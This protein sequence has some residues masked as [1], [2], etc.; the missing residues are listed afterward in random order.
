MTESVPPVAGRT[1]QWTAL[2]L[3]LLV[4]MR[5]VIGSGVSVGTVAAVLSLP[6]WLPA[7]RRYRSAGLLVGLGVFSA[8]FGVWLGQ[9]S[10]ADHGLKFPDHISFAIDMIGL[11]A[12]VGVLLWARQKLRI[13]TIGLMYG[14]GMLVSAVAMDAYDPSNPWKFGIG[15]PAT[16]IILAISAR[17]T[18]RSVDVVVLGLLAA[19]AVATDSRYRFATL[20]IAAFLVL[21]QMVL[22]RSGPRGSAFA[23]VILFV[24]IAAFTY[25]LLSTLLVEGYLGEQAQA[26]SISQIE[27]S[28]S[29]IVG[30]RPELA[31]TAALMAN[32]VWGFGTGVLPTLQDIGIAKTGMASIGYQP[33]NGYVDGYLF[34][35]GFELHSVIGD[36]WASFGLAGI[37]FCV[38]AI[39]I[40]VGGFATVIA[41]RTATGLLLVVSISTM[42]NLF[43]SPLGGSYG[44]LVLAIG[45]LAVPVVERSTRGVG[46]SRT[47]AGARTPQPQR[48]LLDEEPT[49]HRQRNGP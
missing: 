1:A 4:G 36:V 45:L 38:V 16:V 41:A 13:A 39:I 12:S 46:D 26:R 43:F 30:G 27:Q 5:T 20:G 25:N 49:Q 11:V 34:G 9:V 10:A 29:L 8:L 33:D 35:S 24:T 2:A 48:R 17:F 22:G 19:A 32:R 6:I 3:C 47:T 18:N 14:I 40:V 23:T 21:W 31:A 42:W 44:T 37:A 7:L 28:G 15:F